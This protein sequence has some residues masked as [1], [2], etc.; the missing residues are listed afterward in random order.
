LAALGG[1]A[2]VAHLG[3]DALRLQPRPHLVDVS[4][5]ETD[6]MPRLCPQPAQRATDVAAPDDGDP[7]QTLPRVVQAYDGPRQDRLGAL[8]FAVRFGRFAGRAFAPRAASPPSRVGV[9]SRSGNA[10]SWRAEA[11]SSRAA[12]ATGPRRRAAS[13]VTR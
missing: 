3:P 2:D 12:V 5:A 9:S 13:P 4:R 7:H 11:S 8:R 1:R 10:A 6:V